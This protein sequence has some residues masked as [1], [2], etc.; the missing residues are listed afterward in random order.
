MATR[1]T[2]NPQVGLNVRYT[3]TQGV[4]HAGLV[5]AVMGTDPMLLDIRVFSASGTD[6]IVRGVAGIGSA[7]AAI[8]GRS[9]SFVL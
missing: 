9:W 3:D 7:E 6:T 8:Q 4:E 2:P 5:L 1:I